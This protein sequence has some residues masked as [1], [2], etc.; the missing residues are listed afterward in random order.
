MDSKF[1]HLH[2]VT[3]RDAAQAVSCTIEVNLASLPSRCE[4]FSIIV[5][6]SRGRFSNEKA[7]SFVGGQSLDDLR[8]HRTVSF[9]NIQVK[10]T[11]WDETYRA[12]EAG[13]TRR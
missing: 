11:L 8:E 9:C 3:W 4:E 10:E 13:N 7:K 2:L 12:S 5:D 6:L 1:N